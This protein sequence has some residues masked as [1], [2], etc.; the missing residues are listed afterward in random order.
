MSRTK[1][2]GDCTLDQ[3]RQ[4]KPR[5]IEVFG[6]LAE[7]A[8]VGITRIGT[9]YGLKVNLARAP[10]DELA[11]PAKVDGVPVRVEVVGRIAKGEA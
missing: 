1:P 3:A 9:G 10:A 8:G 2:N 5:A 11:L 6:G 4:A 7:V